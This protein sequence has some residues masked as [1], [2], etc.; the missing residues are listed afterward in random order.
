M[1]VSLEAKVPVQIPVKAI[2]SLDE[3]Q[4]GGRVTNILVS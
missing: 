2:S 4:N 1:G 3:N